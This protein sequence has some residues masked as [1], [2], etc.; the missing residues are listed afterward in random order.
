MDSSS[1]EIIRLGPG[2][3]RPGIDI[4]LVTNGQ[5]LEA[6]CAAM[7]AA[8]YWALRHRAARSRMNASGYVVEVRHV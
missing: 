6:T 7:A 3:G 4:Q 2:S 5:S 8:Y 1:G